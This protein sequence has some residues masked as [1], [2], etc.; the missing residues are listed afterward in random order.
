[1]QTLLY[2]YLP[3]E[4]IDVLRDGR[5][6]FTPPAALNDPLECTPTF[7]LS[8]PIDALRQAALFEIERMGA[9][10][11]SECGDGCERADARVVIDEAKRQIESVDK[12]ELARRLIESLREIISRQVGVL[13]LSKDPTCEPLWAHYAEAHSGFLLGLDSSSEYFR[14]RDAL[15][16]RGESASSARASRLRRIKAPDRRR[17]RG[18]VEDPAT[19]S[20][21]SRGVLAPNDFRHGLLGRE[22]RPLTVSYTDIPTAIHVDPSGQIESSQDELYQ[23]LMA[24]KSRVWEV[25]QEVRITRNFS[26][27]HDLVGVDLLGHP[28]R[29]FYIEK[30]AIRQVVLGASATDALANKIRYQLDRH[31]LEQ[32]EIMRARIDRGSRRITIGP[33][34]R[35]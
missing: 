17:I 28:I 33:P 3:P 29:L 8:R 23:L 2:K 6:R 19:P 1:M 18:F 7:D 30:K 20:R 31:D 16:A 13:S 9:Q 25:E 14:V 10:F 35:L 34:L 5:I 11:L 22:T 27:D 4:R 26:G 12:A 32:V 15:A 24:T 21:R